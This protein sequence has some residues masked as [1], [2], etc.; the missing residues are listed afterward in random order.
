MIARPPRRR[1]TFPHSGPGDPVVPGI[2]DDCRGVAHATDHLQWLQ[3]WVR[4]EFGE[5][6]VPTANPWV[7]IQTLDP[8]WS[9]TISLTDTAMQDVHFE[10][11]EIGRTESDWVHCWIDGGIESRYLEWQG[12]GGSSNLE[13]ILALFRSWVEAH[14]STPT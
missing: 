8:G 13:E 7:Q 5:G 12:R 3:E 11:I 1:G 14:S 10:D 9:A 2:R 6:P 4:R